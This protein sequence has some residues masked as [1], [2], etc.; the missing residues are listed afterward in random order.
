MRLP[1]PVEDKLGVAKFDRKTMTLTVTLPVKP[2]VQ[3]PT[4][5]DKISNN[6]ISEENKVVDI[7]IIGKGNDTEIFGTSNSKVSLNNAVDTK[8]A[9][10]HWISSPSP[11]EGDAESF[12][13][14]D[15]I[16]LKAAEARKTL[17][18]ILT[19]GREE[20]EATANS[21]KQPNNVQA[22]PM[23]LSKI[24][25]SGKKERNVSS[26]LE[27][28]NMNANNT[29]STP[30]PPTEVD[31]EFIACS[32]FVGARIGYI[33]GTRSKG[34]GYY[35]DSYTL[36]DPHRMS[37]NE[38]VQ[39]KSCELQ[40]DDVAVPAGMPLSASSF[41][42]DCRETR[43]TIA[44]LV[45]VPLVLPT[46]IRAR[47]VDN[48]LD[49]SFI[50]A[51]GNHIASS[52]YC[53]QNRDSTQSSTTKD[54]Q[55]Q[56]QL[57]SKQSFYGMSFV[58]TS[59]DLDPAQLSVNPA[60]ANVAI[61]IGKL[62][63]S[64]TSVTAGSTPSTPSILMPPR[65]V[66]VEYLHTDPAEILSV[67]SFMGEDPTILSIPSALKTHSL[68][69]TQLTTKNSTPTSTHTHA[70]SSNSENQK[71]TQLSGIESTSAP[72]KGDTTSATPTSTPGTPTKQ[73]GKKTNTSNKSKCKTKDKAAL[74]SLQKATHSLDRR[75]LTPDD[76]LLE[77][78]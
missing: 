43:H 70:K 54:P 27:S 75:Q 21:W 58:I 11:S 50:T 61:V 42:Y 55:H 64:S 66:P 67:V 15:E 39:Q 20:A 6:L 63:L 32:C 18:G 17:E 47:L 25:H 34:T 14:R 60:R 35:I 62:S 38:N 41:P 24:D 68:D 52:N 23:S 29:S 10:N 3:V 48:R 74:G 33:F 40:K 2:S 7:E 30:I 13:L 71:S 8:A 31:D 28:S 73:L 57:Q 77:L 36:S 19:I 59:S 51:S 69:K 65:D 12:R 53:P 9:H 26:A 56:S 76:P 16:A 44:L 37:S 46:S 4:G 22:E 5:V 45:Q 78:F 72:V 1:Y 49:V